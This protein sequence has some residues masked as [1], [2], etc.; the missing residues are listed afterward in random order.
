M[1]D[2]GLWLHVQIVEQK[3]QLQLNHGMSSRV[4]ER[5]QSLRLSYLHV[6]AAER[7]SGKRRRF[8][9]SWQRG[10]LSS[11]TFSHNPP[12]GWFSRF[13]ELTLE[14]VALQPSL[15]LPIHSSFVWK[16]YA[17]FSMLLDQFGCRPSVAIGRC[18]QNACQRSQW[19]RR[20]LA[21]VVCGRSL[22]PSALWR[23][24]LLDRFLQT[25]VFTLM[26][27]QNLTIIDN[28]RLDKRLI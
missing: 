10:S 19:P 28:G 22:F 27:N 14:E 18:Q 17:S 24:D 12:A 9:L 25:W 20:L 11:P 26:F 21:N 16:L 8:R 13:F 2:Y 4:R 6:Q 3:L 7:S 23:L 15:W 1:E 5:V